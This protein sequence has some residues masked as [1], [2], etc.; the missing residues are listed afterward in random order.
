MQAPYAKPD[1]RWLDELQNVVHLAANNKAFKRMQAVCHTDHGAFQPELAKLDVDAEGN[2]R[3]HVHMVETVV[4]PLFEVPGD[5]GLLATMLRLG[6]RFRYEVIDKYRQVRPGRTPLCT[7]A[8]LVAEVRAAIEVIE[9]DAQSR[10]AENLDEATVVDLF[11]SAQDQD[12]MAT[13]L[14]RWNRARERL[15]ADPPPAELSRLRA[16]LEEMREL[17]YRFMCLGSRRFHEMVCT[18]WGDAPHREG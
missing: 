18:R 1:R 14:D 11:T 17:N 15:F 5:I 8:D 7:V 13:V 9:N 4:A 12:D 10:G 16:I 2:L 3:F 6:L